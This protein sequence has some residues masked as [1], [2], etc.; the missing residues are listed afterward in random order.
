MRS[1]NKMQSTAKSQIKNNS[2]TLA[3][4]NKGT[5]TLILT[6]P[7]RPY[8]RAATNTIF[9]FLQISS[10]FSKD[11]SGSCSRKNWVSAKFGRERKNYVHIVPNNPCVVN[12]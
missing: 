12:S 4:I 1:G 3:Q 11:L 2:E 5:L 7:V 10:S 8:E 6:R 9:A